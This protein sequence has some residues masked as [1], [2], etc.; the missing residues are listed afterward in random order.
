MILFDWKKYCKNSSSSLHFVVWRDY[1]IKCNIFL[2]DWS[3]FDA[4]SRNRKHFLHCKRI[5]HLLSAS[6]TLVQY[7]TWQN[8]VIRTNI[9]IV[10]FQFQE[11]LFYKISWECECAYF[12]GVFF[13]SVQTKLIFWYIYWWN[14]QFSQT[15]R[16]LTFLFCSC[17]LLH[18]LTLK[19]TDSSRMFWVFNRA[20]FCF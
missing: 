1:N 17:S 9:N 4:F 11:Y 19:V 13:C 12:V 20:C 16:S 7:F 10:E 5:D 15:I 2:F 8:W 14:F 6:V 3:R 18:F